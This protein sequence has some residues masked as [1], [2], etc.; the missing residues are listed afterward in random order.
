[1]GLMSQRPGEEVAAPRKRFICFCRT[2]DRSVARPPSNHLYYRKHQPV[3]LGV[4][5]VMNNRTCPERSFLLQ[6][7]G[8]KRRGVRKST[9][10]EG[11]LFAGLAVRLWGLVTEGGSGVQV[12]G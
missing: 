1:M 4:R 10:R 7:L 9:E 8:E 2:A 3:S 12:R 5:A 11:G 6:T